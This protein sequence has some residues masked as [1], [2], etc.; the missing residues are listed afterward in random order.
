MSRHFYADIKSRIPSLEIKTVF[1]VG[2]NIGQTAKAISA[3]FP[4]AQIYSF[5][6]VSSTFAELEKNTLD[7]AKIKCFNIA[8]SARDGTA[9]MTAK[10]LSTSNAIRA[11]DLPPADGGETVPVMTGH[12]FCRDE[13]IRNISILKIDTEGH[14]LDVVLGFISLIQLHRVDFIQVEASMNRHNTKHV[15]FRDFCGLLEPLGYAL[16]G[17][18]DQVAEFKKYPYLRRANPVFISD[19][20]RRAT[21]A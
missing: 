13:K 18:Y 10:P 17:I 15:A 21:A 16:F 19:R 7:L 2:A 1:D 11:A 6:P 14:D 8:L 9:T 3:A 4:N 5:E 20:I 12:S